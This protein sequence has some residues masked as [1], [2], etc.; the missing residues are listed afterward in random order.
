M[1]QVQVIVPKAVENLAL[2]DD[3]LLSFYEDLEKRIFWITDE[4]DTY[5]LNLIHYI[6]KWNS[7]D[8]GIPTNLRTPIK[9]LFFSPGG[10][11]DVNYALID[12][13]KMSKT[14]IVGVNL[15]QCASA[16]AYIFLSC[17]K[18]LMMPHSYFLFHQGSGVI[19]GTYGEICA[20]MDDYHNQVT[21][22][23]NFMMLHTHY[24]EEEIM[25][26]IVG[27]WYVRQEE[28]IK[29]GVAHE[30]VTDLDSL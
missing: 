21:E 26:K 25:E 7:E 11:I 27:E 19:S 29:K 20:Q 10:N 6:L 8:K 3:S 24:S 13:I 18:R 12:A 16:A 23:A 22:L 9:L 5:S 2:P 15:G 14:P 28:A 4:I 1:E 30:V 17:H